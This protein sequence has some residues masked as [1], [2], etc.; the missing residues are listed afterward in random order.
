M[1]QVLYFDAFNGVAG[2]MIV[3]ALL[4]LG[5]SPEHLQEQLNLL[6]VGGYELRVD[7][8][9]RQGLRGVDFGVVLPKEAA[10]S[11]DEHHHHH[12]HPGENS[13]HSPAGTWRHIRDL[14]EDSEL[15]ATVRSR[16]LA[17]FERL[18]RAEA[19][20][21]GCAVDDVHSMKSVAPTRSL[22]SSGPASASSSWAST[23]SLR[24]P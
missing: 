21:H 9:E 8:V 18:A 1:G 5:M 22:I 23:S 20:V 16:S 14:I 12:D 4:D 6:P 17:I 11:H 2:D 13:A 15:P 24:L 7:R 10:R 3:G 19:H